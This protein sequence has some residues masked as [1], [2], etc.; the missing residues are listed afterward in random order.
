MAY[1]VKQLQKGL[2][3]KSTDRRAE[4]NALIVDWVAVGP[5]DTGV[6]LPLLERFKQWRDS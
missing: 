3:Q 5:V 1:Q 4:M 6:Y 2:R